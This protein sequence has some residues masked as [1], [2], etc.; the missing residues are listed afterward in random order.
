[1]LPSASFEPRQ[2][3]WQ[4]LTSL[5]DLEQAKN[6]SQQHP[7]V[8]FKH[9]TECPVSASAL[10]R[11]EQGWLQDEENSKITIFYLDLL[12]YRNLSNLIADDF[13]V[14]HES[15][16]ILVITEGRAAAHLSHHQISYP[17]LQEAIQNLS[18]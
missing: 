1:M 14:K 15:P 10:R 18:A 5:A 16:Q 12:R 8:I 4:P 6:L 17:A 13:E 2:A 3:T 7:I 9:S 11:L